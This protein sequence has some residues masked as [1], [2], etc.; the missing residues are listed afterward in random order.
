M[1][2]SIFICV[3]I[4]GNF[5]TACLH[6]HPFFRVKIL[7]IEGHAHKQFLVQ[8]NECIPCALRMYSSFFSLMFQEMTL[9]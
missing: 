7:Y 3:H 6:V 1:I 4:Q 2:Y 5:S 9:G 8:A